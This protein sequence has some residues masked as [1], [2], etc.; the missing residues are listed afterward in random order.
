MKIESPEYSQADLTAFLDE[1]QGHDQQVLADRLQRA[2]RRLAEIAPRVKP[3]RGDSDEWSAVEV[4]AHIAGLSKFYGVMVHR[5][6]SGKLTDLTLLIQAA[7]MRDGSIDEMAGQDPAELLRMTLA[8]H[9]R[10]I[11][12]LRTADSAALRRG[13]PLPDGGTMTAEEVARL[14]LI[15]HVEMH[16]DQLE[17]AL[18]R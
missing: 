6:V 2:S 7:Q 4:L 5:M 16:L 12:E 13:A 9:E 1:M 15:S 14:P 17:K 11:K 3:G 18:T 8:D 10:T